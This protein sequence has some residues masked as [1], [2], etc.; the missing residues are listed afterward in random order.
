MVDCLNCGESIYLTYE[1]SYCDGEYCSECRLPERHNC[2]GADGEPKD[3][4]EAEEPVSG[5]TGLFTDI[6][7]EDDDR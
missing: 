6:N 4:D 2:P 5:I 3:F 1:C 7:E